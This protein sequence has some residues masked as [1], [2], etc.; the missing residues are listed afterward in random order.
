MGLGETKKKRETQRGKA[1]VCSELILE[2]HP[3]V[4]VPQ[5]VHA[6]G[7]RQEP[8]GPADDLVDLTLK[9]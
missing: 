8:L 7:A 4:R 9:T 5:E 2:P 3:G 1:K 6:R